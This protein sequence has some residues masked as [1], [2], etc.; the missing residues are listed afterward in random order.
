MHNGLVLVDDGHCTHLHLST[1]ST[2][3]PSQILGKDQQFSLDLV[4]FEPSRS[5][6]LKRL[7]VL[8]FYG[9]ST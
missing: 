5:F 6:P 7:L 3:S 8:H 2:S 4:T 9:V 1:H